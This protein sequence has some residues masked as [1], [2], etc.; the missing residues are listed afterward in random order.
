MDFIKEN[1]L[2]ARHIG[3]RDIADIAMKEAEPAGL[4][5]DCCYDYLSKRIR[6]NLGKKELEGL[7]RF[8]DLAFEIGEVKKKREI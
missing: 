2:K 8:Q 3:L 5:F 1:M 7:S 4:D 6:Y